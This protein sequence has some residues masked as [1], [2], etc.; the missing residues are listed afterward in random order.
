MINPDLA[1]DAAHKAWLDIWRRDRKRFLT[2]EIDA[3]SEAT[4]NLPGIKQTLDQY[5]RYQNWMQEGKAK[6]RA[7]NE[8]K[9]GFHAFLNRVEDGTNLAHQALG[10]PIEAVSR[11]TNIDPRAIG[12]AATVAAVGKSIKFPTTISKLPVKKTIKSKSKYANEKV[13][14]TTAYSPVEP[15]ANIPKYSSGP[16]VQT[17][18]G[19]FYRPT[20]RLASQFAY[21]TEG[22]G[23]NI[24]HRSSGKADKALL[25]KDVKAWI[26][27]NSSELMRGTKKRGDFG[28]IFHDN[29]LHYIVGLGEHLATGGQTNFDIRPAGGNIE[30]KIQSDPANIKVV[31]E[32]LDYVNEAFD[33]T[34]GK[35]GVSREVLNPQS[36]RKLSMKGSYYMDKITQSLAKE[37]NLP[38]QKGHM[39]AVLG[40]EGLGPNVGESQF[41]QHGTDNIRLSN[42]N[43]FTKEQFNILNLPGPGST[44]KS[45]TGHEQLGWIQAAVRAAAG[46]K[47]KG[48]ELTLS[49]KIALQRLGKKM[50][51][52]DAAY[53]ILA[54]REVLN[55]A[56]EAGLTGP[57]EMAVLKQHLT[58][59]DV[60]QQIITAKNK[61]ADR[62]K[63][64]QYESRTIQHYPKEKFKQLPR[65]EPKG[66][67]QPTITESMW[68]ALKDWELID[69]R[70]NR[71]WINK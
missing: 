41:G 52:T 28:T 59:I 1:K 10:M 13:V 34:N 63:D 70:S 44:T 42:L 4:R 36:F 55:R 25:K 30:R 15:K 61:A 47:F 20:E 35:F 16:I 57:E 7:Y 2:K 69:A 8:Q 37:W 3:V 60:E 32:W 50:N 53:M 12:A 45:P 11:V 33:E 51:P 29:R 18:E 66:K 27:Q 54:Q 68:K 62:K 71:L 46:E 26:K 64:F 24:I 43:D 40:K 14:D 22:A 49:D 23:K 48:T 39:S 58:E 31:N 19:T 17:K 5:D 67:K 9:G 65:A 6:R 56:I 21:T 38:L